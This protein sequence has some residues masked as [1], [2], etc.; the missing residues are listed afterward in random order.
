MKGIS[1]TIGLEFDIEPFVIEL[2]SPCST[3][4][5][6][7]T[8]DSSPQRSCLGL[9]IWTSTLAAISMGLQSSPAAKCSAS[10]F[11][12]DTKDVELL[13][14]LFSPIVPSFTLRGPDTSSQPVYSSSH[15]LLAALLTARSVRRPCPDTSSVRRPRDHDQ[16]STEHR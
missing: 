3:P 6:S 1:R 9:V 12:S 15:S 8:R 14:F 16:L 2:D 13:D 11:W 4:P 7:P 10:D 5:P